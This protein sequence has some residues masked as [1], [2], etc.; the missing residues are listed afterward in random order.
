[1]V[2]ATD[3]L[4]AA[5]DRLVVELRIPGANGTSPRALCSFDASAL[6]GV[7]PS[8]ALLT[9]PAGQATYIVRSEHDFSVVTN[10]GWHLNYALASV[11]RAA[12]GSAA[13]GTVTL[14]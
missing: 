5:D 9:L 6:G 1:V 8:N 14:Q 3:G 4:P 7:I 11:A 10:D 2:W 13:T 12:D